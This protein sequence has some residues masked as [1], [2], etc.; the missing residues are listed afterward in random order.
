M[1]GF[2]GWSGADWG[3]PDISSAQKWDEELGELLSVGSGGSR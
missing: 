3:M 2:S 1:E